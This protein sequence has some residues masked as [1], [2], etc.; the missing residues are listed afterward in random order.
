MKMIICYF[1]EK[2]LYFFFCLCRR[3]FF[4]LNLVFMMYGLLFISFLICLMERGMN[5]Y[6]NIMY[7]F[8][9][10]KL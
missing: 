9:L 3:I 7:M 5:K 2:Y 6:M 10:L 8:K 1:L 4:L